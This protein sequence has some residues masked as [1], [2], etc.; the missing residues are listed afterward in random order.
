MEQNATDQKTTRVGY[1]ASDATTKTFESGKKVTNVTILSGSG[2]NKTATY[3]RGW[4][5]M[6][7]RLADIRTGEKWEF[8]GD[9]KVETKDDKSFDVMT[10][11]EAYPHIKKEIQGEVKHINDKK[12]GKTDMKNIMVVSSEMEGGKEVSNVYNIELYGKKNMDKANG[13]KVGDIVSTK[14]HVR[15]Y[16]YQKDGELKVNRS[17]QN[18]VEIE[19]HTV[20]KE[21]KMSVDNDIKPDV[22]KAP[23][24]KPKGKG[25][26]M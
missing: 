24:A 12:L 18:P 3:V 25:V 6:A 9:L 19:N 4:N 13:I 5:A 10:A 20:S 17:F 26:S 23:K 16:D 8:K 21:K 11:R 1:V 15:M 22:A 14:G 2:E 7:D